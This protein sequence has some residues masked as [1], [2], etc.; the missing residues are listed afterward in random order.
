MGMPMNVFTAL[1]PKLLIPSDCMIC[2]EFFFNF[3]YF[4]CFIWN[5]AGRESLPF[6]IFFSSPGN[7]M[8]HAST[9]ESNWVRIIYL[10][11]L[12]IWVW[13]TVAGESAH[14]S[15]SCSPGVTKAGRIFVVCHGWQTHS[16]HER[17]PLWSCLGVSF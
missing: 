16:Y 6:F 1:W 2:E 12:S 4:L 11:F 14:T 7:L 15:F 5:L 10:S 17:R 3:N 8:G 13:G 9:L